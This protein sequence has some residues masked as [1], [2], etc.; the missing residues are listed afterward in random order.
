ML[1][2]GLLLRSYEIPGNIFE[3][4]GFRIKHGFYRD[5]EGF[6]AGYS[7]N[8]FT[9]RGMRGK[10]LINQLPPTIKNSDRRIDLL[11]SL[12]G[13]YRFLGQNVGLIWMRTQREGSL[14]N[15]SSILMEGLLPFE[16][17]YKM[18]YS[19]K[20][21]PGSR[22]FNINEDLSYAFYGNLSFAVSN[23]GGLFEIKKYNEYVLGA[24]YN[25]PPGLVKE[26]SSRVLN[27]ST[28]IPQISNESG[29]Q[30]EL[31][32]FFPGGMTLTFNTAR[33]INQIID[34]DLFSEYYLEIYTPVGRG[35]DIKVFADYAE[36]QF[37]SEYNRISTGVQWE[38]T[39]S[40]RWGASGDIEFQTFER[41]IVGK[42]RVNNGVATLGFNKLN[43]FSVEVIWEFSTDPFLVDH[44]N[45]FEVE[46]GK[47]QWWGIQFGHRFDG[48]HNIQLFAGQRRGGP[49]CASGICYEVL[50]FEGIEIKLTSKF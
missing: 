49:A 41:R 27:R 34:R 30:L 2:N 7:G 6:M 24:G 4:Q 10:V 44:P 29:I 13:E 35:G 32:Y 21:G 28:H 9:V 25:D 38:K 46:T 20:I 22:P 3:D 31:Y 48:H 36:D 37:R 11:E 45:T 33:A 14:N 18:E 5:I 47:R 1:G 15:Y 43:R 16:L 42:E 12:E 40:G 26:H 50:D 39:L 8:N 23:F 17:S 19:Q